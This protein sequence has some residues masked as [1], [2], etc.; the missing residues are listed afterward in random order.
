MRGHMMKMMFAIADA[1]G[2][3][4]LTFEEVTAIHQRIFTAMDVN[5]DGKVTPDEIRVF[6]QD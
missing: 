6:M 2:D 3:G 5:R 4:A 1:D